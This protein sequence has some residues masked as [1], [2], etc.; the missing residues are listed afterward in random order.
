MS[1]A[2]DFGKALPKL[3]KR[4]EADLRKRKLE[5]RHRGRGG[6]PAARHRPHPGRQRSLCARTTRATARPPCA[7]ATP[8]CAGRTVKMR[9]KAK[10][11]IERELSI[12]DTTLSPDRRQMPGPAR[13]ESVPVRRRATASRAGQLDR[14][15]RLYP[16]SDRRGFHRQAFPHLERE[17]HRLRA[18]L[19]RRRRGRRPQRDARAG[20]RGA[21]Q[22][23]GDQPQILCPSGADRGGEGR[24]RAAPRLAMSRAR[25]NICRAP[26]A[27]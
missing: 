13:P 2:A 5:P 21:R 7:T 18:D 1:A 6:R 20:R 19:R 14:R 8:R 26:S 16:R 9:F 11:G 17:R 15:Q 25:R 22:H 4:V 10:S 27:G 3:R 12:T 24:H 23:A